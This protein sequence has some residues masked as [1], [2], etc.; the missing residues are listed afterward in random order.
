[1]K[2]FLL[3]IVLVSCSKKEHKIVYY[4]SGELLSEYYLENNK[5]NGIYKE[6]YRN[7]NLKETHNYKNDIRI[8]SSIYYYKEPQKNIRK[9]E[10]HISDSIS[11]LIFYNYKANKLIK[12]EGMSYK[13]SILIGKWKYY[14]NGILIRV[15]EYKNIENK[16]YLNQEWD[17]NVNGD[18]ICLSTFFKITKNVKDTLK[19]NQEFVSI[20][21]VRCPYYK[22]EDS[23]ILVCLPNSETKKMNKD[24]SNIKELG[25]KCFKDFKTT[26][27]KV[28]T[29][30]V[31]TKHLSRITKKFKTPGEKLVR[32]II[33][34]YLVKE[35]DS[36]GLDRALENAHK[37]Y[38]EIPVFVKDSV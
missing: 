25:Y 1:M 11:K 13:D 29:E 3:I 21:H 28:S 36:I 32:G 16:T 17:F 19:L 23:K 10:N 33:Y 31:N 5:L 2:Y 22:L 6:Y 37:M 9:I 27:I 12:S 14:I 18:T 15:S 24:F 8:D 38:F 34:E 26:K 30:D 20:V 35:K 4:N 7:G